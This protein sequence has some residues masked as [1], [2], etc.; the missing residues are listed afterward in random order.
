VDIDIAEIKIGERGKY[1]LYRS[2]VSKFKSCNKV[3]CINGVSYIAWIY[4]M[5]I[6]Q[7]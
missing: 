6:Y 2:F 1:E 3:F 5:Q 4:S 7:P